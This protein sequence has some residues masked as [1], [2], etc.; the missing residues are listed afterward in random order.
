MLTLS[1]RGRSRGIKFTICSSY[2]QRGEPSMILHFVQDDSIILAAYLV[3]NLSA[4]PH[5]P[6]YQSSIAHI[7]FITARRRRLDHG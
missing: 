5:K 3:R 4:P 6:A 7:G 1:S 2:R